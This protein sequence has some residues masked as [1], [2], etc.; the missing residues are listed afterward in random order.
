[1]DSELEKWIAFTDKSTA[2]FHQTQMN[3]PHHQKWT[4]LKQVK[5]TSEV[6][7]EQEKRS[8]NEQTIHVR[9]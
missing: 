3:D 4:P 5:I 9:V 8:K 1:M 7:H 6:N 2:Q